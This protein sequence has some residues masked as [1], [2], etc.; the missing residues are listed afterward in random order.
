MQGK[1]VMKWP[2]VVYAET[3]LPNGKKVKMNKTVD[4]GG[5]DIDSVEDA[6]LFA[7][8]SRKDGGIPFIGCEIVAEYARAADW[9]CDSWPR[10]RR[11]RSVRY[12]APMRHA[13]RAR[14]SETP[15]ACHS[16][17]AAG[18]SAKLSASRDHL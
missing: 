12:G 16:S 4:A 10:R 15:A 11:A 6:M 13:R 5:E 2:I 7:L 9:P 1:K 8:H 3:Y 17:V 14:E 18:R